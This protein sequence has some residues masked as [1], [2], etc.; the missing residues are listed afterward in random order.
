[1]SN[2]K[3]FTDKELAEL[4]AAE[5]NNKIIYENYSLL[6]TL[7]GEKL[8]KEMVPVGAA[9]K[10]AVN[11]FLNTTGPK[12]NP[13]KHARAARRKLVKTLSKL[14]P[15]DYKGFP[16]DS[17]RGLVI[18]FNHPSLGE[19]ARILMMKIDVMGEKPMLFPVNLPWYEALA[20][21]FDKIKQLGIIITPTITPATWKKLDLK[22][23]TKLYENANAIKRGF[24][25]M[26]I[27][28]SDEAV[29]NGGVIFVAP[30]ATRQEK[31]FKTPEVYNGDEEI[32]PTM[33]VLALRLYRDPMMNCDFLPMGVLP[34][35]DYKRGLNFR[36]KYRLIPGEVMTAEYIREKYFGDKT[37]ERLEGF[38]REF[39]QRIAD[40]LPKEFW[41]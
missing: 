20:T 37:P 14:T 1:M 34:P 21:D 10:T 17:E 12:N 4:S 6:K 23:G 8:R 5:I 3:V 39:H 7:G 9:C 25:D 31:V 30:S 11:Y 18:G 33:S 22:E 41:Y 36:K 13:E 19:I 35:K 15:G 26:Y 32:I 27:M 38:D 24:R 29:K 28:R 16:E 40:T 2:K